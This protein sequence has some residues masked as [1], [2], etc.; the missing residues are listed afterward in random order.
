MGSS[1]QPFFCSRAPGGRTLHPLPRRLPDR[2]GVLS[3]RALA[4]GARGR[5][6]AGAGARGPPAAETASKP[7]D[8]KT[9]PPARGAAREGT[10][11]P[12]AS[13]SR[14]RGR[15]A[16]ARARARGAGRPGARRWR[17]EGSGGGPPNPAPVD[18]ASGGGCGARFFRLRGLLLFRGSQGA[19]PDWI[20]FSLD[21]FSLVW[22]MAQTKTTPPASQPLV[23]GADTFR[24]RLGPPPAAPPSFLWP[25]W[26]PPPIRPKERERRRFVSTLLELSIHGRQDLNPPPVADPADETSAAGDRR[27][28]SPSNFPPDPAPGPPVRPPRPTRR[29]LGAPKSREPGKIIISPKKKP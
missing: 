17:G 22:H 19:W 16:R 2:A 20:S 24:T 10:A 14:A 15:R 21:S 4:W 29:E 13:A 12:P 11:P 3:R 7:A 28:F 5:A 25:G 23:V 1:A 26:L 9:G 8:P 27:H 18:P 6:G